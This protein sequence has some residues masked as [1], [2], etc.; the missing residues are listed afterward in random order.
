MSAPVMPTVARDSRS[1][2]TSSASGTPREWTSNSSSPAGQRRPIDRD[3]PIEPAGPQQRR[4]EHVGP[5]RGR[6]H[7]HGA[8][9]AE[10]VH[11]AEDL[12]E[13]L[14]AFVVSAAE[15][16]AALPADGVDFVDEQDRRANWPGPFGTCRARGRRRRPR[17][18]G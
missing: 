4:V 13:R 8:R 15:A 16:G 7:D 12:V 6:Q 17:T 1:K 11:L 9:G 5:V 2:S 18:T 3:V 14:L 10:A